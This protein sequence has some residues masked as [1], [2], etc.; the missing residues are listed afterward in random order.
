MRTMLKVAM[1]VEAGNRAIKD[2]VLSSTVQA[3]IDKIKPE[4]SYFYAENGKRTM[5]FIF[6]LKEAAQIPVLAEPLFQSLNAEVQF[7]PAM[8]YADL[9]SGL[10][11]VSGRKHGRVLAEV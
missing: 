6:D 5:L 4:S 1:P 8:N 10:Q 9:K 11:K 3:M 2:G 7:Y